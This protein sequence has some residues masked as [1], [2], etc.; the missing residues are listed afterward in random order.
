M[1]IMDFFNHNTTNLRGH[2]V[3]IYLEVNFQP[4]SNYMT[5]WNSLSEFMVSAPY[6]NVF[7][8]RVDNK[9]IMIWATY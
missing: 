2:N 9:W 4:E 3:P 7:K 5:V 8:N 1:L 6:T